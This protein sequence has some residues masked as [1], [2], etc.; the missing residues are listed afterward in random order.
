M[1]SIGILLHILRN[2]LNMENTDAFLTIDDL[3]LRDVQVWVQGSSNIL[4]HIE[5]AQQ[6]LPAE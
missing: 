6:Q 5:L 2:V 4:V 3:S 1:K